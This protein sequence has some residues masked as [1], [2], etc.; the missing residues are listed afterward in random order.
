MPQ[1][2]DHYLKYIL[3]NDNHTILNVNI[4]AHLKQQIV[5]R[6]LLAV[7]MSYVNVLHE[8]YAGIPTA[9]Q[10]GRRQ[11]TTT[12]TITR[13]KFLIFFTNS[14]CVY[15][16]SLKY[17]ETCVHDFLTHIARLAARSFAY[18][19]SSMKFRFNFARL[20]IFKFYALIGIT[21]ICVLFC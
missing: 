8:K 16:P 12:T 1:Q 18:S 14:M 4:Q 2:D 17:S 3:E 9:I 19:A 15:M 7:P 13:N 20:I 21:H 10:C 6:S 11:T 5:K